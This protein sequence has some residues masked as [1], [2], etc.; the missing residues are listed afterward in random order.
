MGF[1]KHGRSRAADDEGQREREEEGSTTGVLHVGLSS[2]EGALVKAFAIV[3]DFTNLC[4]TKL[5]FVLMDALQQQAIGAAIVAILMALH[6]WIA[7]N[8]FLQSHLTNEFSFSRDDDDD[9]QLM[10][11][12]VCVVQCIAGCALAQRQRK[13][14]AVG[15]W[16]VK[17]RSRHFWET[18]FDYTQGDDIRFEEN[19]RIPRACFA[20]VCDLLRSNLEQKLIPQ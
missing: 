3:K 6:Q 16:Y 4:V 18:F 20:Y 9:D 7:T 2:A 10:A 17:P 5:H 14:S 13:R 12:V 1:C 11:R 8:D 19:L 15:E